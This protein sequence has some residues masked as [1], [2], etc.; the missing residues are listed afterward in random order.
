MLLAQIKK[1]KVEITKLNNFNITAM[2]RIQNL[3]AVNSS[4]NMADIFAKTV[5][6][7]ERPPAEGAE[8]ER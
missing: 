2:N 8:R 4:T 6:L 5:G 3:D 7:P 1:Y